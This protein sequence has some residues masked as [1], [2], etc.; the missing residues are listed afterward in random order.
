MKLSYGAPQG[1]ALTWLLR[2]T[3]MQ[4]V[5]YKI[6]RKRLISDSYF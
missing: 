4:L 2:A 1:I 5:L 6:A 3:T